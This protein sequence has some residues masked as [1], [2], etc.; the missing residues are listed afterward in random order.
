MEAATVWLKIIHISALLFWSATLFYLPGLLAAHPR[1]DDVT[2]FYRIRTITRVTYLAIASPS[3]II[4]VISGSAL[5]YV[6]G[7]HGGW[8]VLKLIA[9]AMMVAFHVYIG[10]VVA[11]MRVPPVRRASAALL[12]LIIIPAALVPAVFYL[13][14]A[15]PV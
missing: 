3:A 7:V 8:L 11:E 1:A 12:S 5:I 15:K 14:L 10:S 9:V 2:A 13:V 6:A 4:A